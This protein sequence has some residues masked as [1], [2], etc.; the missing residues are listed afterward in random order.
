MSSKKYRVNSSEHFN[1][2]SMYEHQMVI[3]DE[4]RENH[5]ADTELKAELRIAE[6][7]G[8]LEEAPCVGAHV[9]WST[10]NRI[11][12]IADERRIIRYATCL[13]AGDTEEDAAIALTL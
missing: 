6:L 1:L 7:E 12:Q 11:R 9:D 10:L 5:D 2:M 3:R 4:A 13:A 8:L